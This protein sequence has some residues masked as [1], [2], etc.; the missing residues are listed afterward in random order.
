MKQ[1]VNAHILGMSESTYKVRVILD[2]L[3]EVELNIRKE[4]IPRRGY[5]DSAHWFRS[6][7]GKAWLLGL[8]IGKKVDGLMKNK[9]VKLDVALPGH[10]IMLPPADWKDIADD[11][12]TAR[13]IFSQDLTPASEKFIRYVETM[14][15]T[16]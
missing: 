4:A 5:T 1:V 2:P 8:V 10:A 14:E 7:G 9:P 11:L 13:A 12:H 3:E 15:E 16:E 6:E